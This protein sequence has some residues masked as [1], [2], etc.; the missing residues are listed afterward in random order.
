MTGED[1]AVS[2]EVER[3][4]EANQSSIADIDAQEA[5]LEDTIRASIVAD[6][7]AELLTLPAPVIDRWIKAYRRGLER[8]ET[9]ASG[10]TS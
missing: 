2:L 6:I 4:D 3:H 8:A 5:C 10:V 9:I 7:R 1:F